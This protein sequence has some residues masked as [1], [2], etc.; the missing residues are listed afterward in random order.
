MQTAMEAG[1]HNIVVDWLRSLN[2]LHYTQAF[3]D[4]GYDD[5]EVC[6]QIGSVDLDAIDVRN[7]L[8]REALLNAVK[9]LREEGGTNVYFT[10]EASNKSPVCHPFAMFNGNIDRC[11]DK[12]VVSCRKT[13]TGSEN[14]CNNTLEIPKLPPKHFAS[15]SYESVI[16]EQNKCS[17]SN[18]LMDNTLLGGNALSSVVPTSF[19]SSAPVCA[20]QSFFTTPITMNMVSNNS[21]MQ[22][23]AGAAGLINSNSVINASIPRIDSCTVGNSNNFMTFSKLQLRNILQE[24][25]YDDNVCLTDFPYT[26]QVSGYLFFFLVLFTIIN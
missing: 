22:R 11:G 14:C 24:Q 21:T 16:D 20:T 5:L 19:F 10:L 26:T 9:V 13:D 1:N 8:H 7:Q 12:S 25:L 2:L 17:L 3:L 15:I 6:K 4:N 18:L 23:I